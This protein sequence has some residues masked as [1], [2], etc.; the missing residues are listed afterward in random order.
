MRWPRIDYNQRIQVTNAAYAKFRQTAD[1]FRQHVKSFAG[2]SPHSGIGV[3]T[4]DN[5]YI[6]DMMRALY[7]ISVEN[8]LRISQTE[9]FSLLDA[10]KDGIF[11]D[12]KLSNGMHRYTNKLWAKKDI[13]DLT[14]D[15]IK[16][17]RTDSHIS[18]SRGRGFGPVYITHIVVLTLVFQETNRFSDIPEVMRAA[19]TTPAALAAQRY[20]TAKEDNNRRR[21]VDIILNNPR[22]SQKYRTRLAAL[23]QAELNKFKL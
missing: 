7:R 20:E 23:N 5:S 17:L 11:P 19:V 2:F 8:L 6:D 13:K 10:T 1:E 14:Q 18:G 3:N 21:E 15:D 12:V 16:T 9:K 22:C 4:T